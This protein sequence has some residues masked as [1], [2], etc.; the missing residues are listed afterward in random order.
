[1]LVTLR[2]YRV[3]LIKITGV[4]MKMQ[5]FALPYK[6]VSLSLFFKC[7]YFGMLNHSI[8]CQKPCKKFP[9]N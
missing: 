1:M 2:G 4:F 8:S 3:R 7:V 6:S 9:K 5:W